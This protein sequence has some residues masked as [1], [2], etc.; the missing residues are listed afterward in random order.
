M[1]QNNL[2]K[3]NNDGFV[4]IRNLIPKK[5]IPFV[6]KELKKMSTILIQNYGSPYVHLTKD[7]KLNTAH[8]LDKIFPKSKLMSLKK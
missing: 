1:L 7:F 4:V 3:F 2:K 5:N 8:H 6:K